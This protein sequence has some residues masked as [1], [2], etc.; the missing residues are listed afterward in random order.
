FG[1]VVRKNLASLGAT[2]LGYD[3]T[4]AERSITEWYDSIGFPPEFIVVVE[5]RYHRIL[6]GEA[7]ALSAQRLLNDGV[8]V[9]HI[10]GGIDIPHLRATKLQLHPAQPAAIGRMSVT[11]D[12]VGLLP[13]I[14]LHV[15]GLR[16]GEIV[17]RSRRTGLTPQHAVGA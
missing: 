7:P 8:G 16:V 11:T 17:V 9:I 4:S 2:V 6:I 10:C 15:A 13:V 1:P 5:H 14:K 12:Y 3:P